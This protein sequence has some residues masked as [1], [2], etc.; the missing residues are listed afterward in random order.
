MADTEDAKFNVIYLSKKYDIIL[1]RHEGE[2]YTF[3][4]LANGIAEKCGVPVGKQKVICKGKT[5]TSGELSSSLKDLG[6]TPKDKILL[7]GHKYNEEETKHMKSIEKVDGNVEELNNRLKEKKNE[8]SGVGQGF[9]DS[10]QRKEALQKLKKEIVVLGEG[11]MKLLESLDALE[12]DHS[13]TSVRD[14]RKALIKKIQGYLTDTDN[15]ESRIKDL[16]AKL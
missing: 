8:I 13:L 15:E 2:E 1:T 5:L 9:L 11:F 10:S 4:D 14:K 7:I 16:V 3:Q 6:V 12:V